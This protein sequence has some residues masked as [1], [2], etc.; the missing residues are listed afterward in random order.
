MISLNHQNP[1]REIFRDRQERRRLAELR[2]E[3]ILENDQRHRELMMYAS[4][5]GHYAQTV[6]RLHAA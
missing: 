6:R 1:R 4:L 5:S 2:C 3:R